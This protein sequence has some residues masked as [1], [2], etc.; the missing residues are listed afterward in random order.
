VLLNICV[1]HLSQTEF[2]YLARAENLKSKENKEFLAW[3]ASEQTIS[4]AFPTS[5]STV[6]YGCDRKLTS[7]TPNENVGW[8]LWDGELKNAVAS[9]LL[10]Q[11]YGLQNYSLVKVN[12]IEF[13]FREIAQFVSVPAL[14]Q[15]SNSED[16]GA[17]WRLAMEPLEK[18]Y[19]FERLDA[20]LDMLLIVGLESGNLRD[21]LYKIPFLYRLVYDTFP[22][23][24]S[25]SQSDFDVRVQKEG[26]KIVENFTPLVELQ[27]FLK[28]VDNAPTVFPVASRPECERP[29]TRDKVLFLLSEYKNVVITIMAASV[30]LQKIAA[31]VP[32]SLEADGVLFLVESRHAEKFITSVVESVDYVTKNLL[33]YIALL[34]I[35]FSGKPDTVILYKTDLLTPTNTD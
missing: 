20:V 29:S 12:L 26:L 25:L 19:D 13:V 11:E 22:D 27:S 34:K 33:G 31:A 35:T 28:L 2:N 4:Y 15:L 1:K 5:Y 16:K 32:V 6:E 18:V 14:L 7:I 9:K 30:V 3:Y 8:E 17:D 23:T 21:D 24:R 10:T